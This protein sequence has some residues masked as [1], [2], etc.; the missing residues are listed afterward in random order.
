MSYL[1]KYFIIVLLSILI[2]S[3]GA[4]GIV[5][6]IVPQIPDNSSNY[7]KTDTITTVVLDMLSLIIYWI[8]AI[9]LSAILICI[10]TQ[11]LG[12]RYLVMMSKIIISFALCFGILFWVMRLLIQADYIPDFVFCLLTFITANSGWSWLINDLKIHNHI[13]TFFAKGRG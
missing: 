9:L 2:V 8:G 11:Y 7:F 6:S 3:C 10:L 4:T 12:N 5:N 1:F 13:S